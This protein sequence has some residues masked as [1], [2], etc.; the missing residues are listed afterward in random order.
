ERLGA[1]DR[2]TFHDV[3]ELTSAVIA[4]TRIPFGVLVREYGTSRFEYRSADE[5]F[6]GDELEAVVLAMDFVFD[7][8]GDLGIRFAERS[9]DQV[10]C[11][12]AHDS[13]PLHYTF[14][15]SASAI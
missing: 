5:V 8:I 3:D 14:S 7:G 6:R 1:R 9:P 13:G 12:N 10:G 2:R 15:R 4:L 11:F